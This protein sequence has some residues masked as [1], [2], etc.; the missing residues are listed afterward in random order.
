MRPLSA[1]RAKGARGSER[2][3]GL[4][5][6][7]PALDLRTAVLCLGSGVVSDWAKGRII[8]GLG[9]VLADAYEDLH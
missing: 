2:K 5:A 7:A 9:P 4:L 3:E 8:N 1:A 6:P